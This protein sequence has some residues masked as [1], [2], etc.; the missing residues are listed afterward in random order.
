MHE[1]LNRGVWR[2]LEDYER[3]LNEDSLFNVNVEI[4]I[5]FSNTSNKVDGGAT[6]PS[7]FTKIITYSDSGL[8]R[9]PKKHTTEAYTFPNNSSVKGKKKEDYFNENLSGQFLHH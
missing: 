7:S 2:I 3:T 9:Y 1:T 4:V 6:I 8:I 5:N